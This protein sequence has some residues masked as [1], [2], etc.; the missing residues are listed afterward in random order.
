M[1]SV[2]TP[3]VYSQMTVVSTCDDSVPQ[4]PRPHSGHDSSTYLLAFPWGLNKTVIEHILP[5]GK[6]S[7]CISY[8]CRVLLLL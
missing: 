8:C 4:Y 5:A 6:F 1:G 7:S 3:A 2:P